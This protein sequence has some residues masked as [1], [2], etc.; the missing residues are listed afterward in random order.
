[1]K[2]IHLKQAEEL[3]RRLVLGYTVEAAIAGSNPQKAPPPKKK[4]KSKGP[5]VR[6]STEYVNSLKGDVKFLK[7]VTDLREVGTKTK[8]FNHKQHYHEAETRKQAR[9]QL[10][11]MS[12]IEA[13]KEKDLIDELTALEEV[14]EYFIQ[15]YY[16]STTSN[17]N[18]TNYYT[19]RTTGFPRQ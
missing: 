18:C 14:Y 11:K 7:K 4:D 13:V 10:K 9:K 17:Q 6:L 15:I 8:E 5:A 2:K 16:I 19:G 1:M 12:K 3:V